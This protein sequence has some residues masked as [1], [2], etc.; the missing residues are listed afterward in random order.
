[1]KNIFTLTLICLSALIFSNNAS[2]QTKTHTW[3]KSETGIWKVKVDT[4]VISYKIDVDWV[5]WSSTDEK[6]WVEVPK[7]MWTDFEGNVYRAMN[8]MIFWSTDGG[9]TWDNAPGQTWHGGDGMW[10]KFDNHLVLFVSQ[11]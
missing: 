11:Q 8:Q 4:K 10:Y 3:N 1:M 9:S 5:V 6:K 7:N 2:A